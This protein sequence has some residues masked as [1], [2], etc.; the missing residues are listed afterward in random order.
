VVEV[1]SRSRVLHDRA[2]KRMIYEQFGI[3]E[4]W[5]VEPN[6]QTVELFALEGREY[7]SLGVFQGEQTLPSRMV[8][9]MDVL[10]AQFFA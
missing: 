10:V 6:Q 4:Y 1:I 7:R 5:L 9:H 2:L 8:P 3:P